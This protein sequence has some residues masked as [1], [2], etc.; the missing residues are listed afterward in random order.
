MSNIIYKCSGR[1]VKLQ[2]SVARSL[3][4]YNASKVW[5]RFGSSYPGAELQLFQ[6]E[7]NN[8]G[9]TAHIWS[10]NEEKRRA[11]CRGG[12]V[13][14]TGVG[15]GALRTCKGV[16]RLCRGEAWEL[17]GGLD[18]SF[19]RCGGAGPGLG[20]PPPPA[21]RGAS[22]RRRRRTPVGEEWIE[23]V[24]EPLRSRPTGA[25]NNTQ[26]ML[27]Q[28]P[29]TNQV[30]QQPQLPGWAKAEGCA[31]ARR[32]QKR[33]GERIERGG[34]RVCLERKKPPQ[35]TTK[36]NPVIKGNKITTPLI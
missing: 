16:K 10:G 26:D 14:R 31:A 29:K 34:M 5:F 13:M 24:C 22:A 9:R 8:R 2:D 3:T 15:G 18:G 11:V 7:A 25:T 6:L 20:L 30:K 35:K 32:G 23:G 28:Q 4:S 33:F 1:L 17:L 19:L 21:P 12:G 27:D 36:Q